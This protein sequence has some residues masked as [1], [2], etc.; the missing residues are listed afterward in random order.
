MNTP[1][2]AAEAICSAANIVSHDGY[3]EV[4]I[5]AVAALIRQ[6]DR[7]VYEAAYEVALVK[8]AE[9]AEASGDIGAASA[10][11]SI[12]ALTPEEML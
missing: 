8:A 10:A 2:Q 6:R 7:E 3:Y 9:C 5:E 1:E 4:D 11:I 12:R